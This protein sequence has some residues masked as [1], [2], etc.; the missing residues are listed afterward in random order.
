MTIYRL[1]IALALGGLL[2]ACSSTP[3]RRAL[4]LPPPAALRDAPAPSVRVDLPRY[5]DHRSLRVRSSSQSLRP[6]DTQAWAESPAEGVERLLAERLAASSALHSDD[7]IEVQ[8]YRFERESDGVFRAVGQWRVL[9]SGEA[10]YSGAVG[11]DRRLVARGAE[12]ETAQA[13]ALVE[14]MSAA[15][16]AI[17]DAII[18]ETTGG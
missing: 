17:A 6:I 11:F 15:V 12:A 3:E 16:A 7:R 4:Y 1:T 5:I 2:A 13:T 8:L 18:T 14:A 9:R 10:L